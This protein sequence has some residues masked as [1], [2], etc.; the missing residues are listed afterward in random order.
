MKVTVGDE[1]LVIPKA[2]LKDIETVEIHQEGN[3]II[4]VPVGEDPIWGLG[5]DPLQDDIT[6]ASVNHDAYLTKL[7]QSF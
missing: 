3:V 6:D 1:G 4:V 5:S 2:L 7:G